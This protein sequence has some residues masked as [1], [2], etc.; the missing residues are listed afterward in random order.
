MDGTGGTLP[1]NAPEAP[2]DELLIPGTAGATGDEV[3]VGGEETVGGEEMVGGEELVDGRPGE[4][5][6]L[7]EPLTELGSVVGG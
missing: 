4:S 6:G 2:V 1:T 5:A 3:P 7:G